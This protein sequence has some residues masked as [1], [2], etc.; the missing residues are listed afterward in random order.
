MWLRVA[1]CWSL[2]LLG[3]QLKY[4][5]PRYEDL[6]YGITFSVTVLRH[7]DNERLLPSK[8]EVPNSSTN[9][10]SKTQPYIVGHEDEHEE[11]A[12]YN[13]NDV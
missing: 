1:E 12:K 7:I 5:N 11:V 10:N 13:L 6:N 8:E 2:G 9:N 4:Y 3:N